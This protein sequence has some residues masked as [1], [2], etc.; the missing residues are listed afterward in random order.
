MGEIALNL[1]D[2]QTAIAGKYPV[3][4]ASYKSKSNKRFGVKTTFEHDASRDQKIAQVTGPP[5]AMQ[6]FALAGGGRRVVE[7]NSSGQVEKLTDYVQAQKLNFLSA[8]GDFELA[9]SN[10]KIEWKSHNPSG[11][12]EQHGSMSNVDVNNIVDL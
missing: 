8:I 7:Y 5:K 9:R 12:T 3:I 10:G 11:T 4:L 2:S 1:P 6:D